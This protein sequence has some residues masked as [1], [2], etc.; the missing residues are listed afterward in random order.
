MY[1]VVNGKATTT[2]HLLL[3]KAINL[4]CFKACQ[5]NIKVSDKLNAMAAGN[6]SQITSVQNI[7]HVFVLCCS[8]QI[9]HAILIPVGFL[10]HGLY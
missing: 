10:L 3:S 7:M 9:M 5:A 2:A 6:A 1:N 8:T 4:Q